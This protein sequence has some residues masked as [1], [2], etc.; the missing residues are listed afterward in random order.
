M[1]CIKKHI[2]PQTSI[3]SDCWKS[4]D[5]LSVEGYIHHTVNHS[6]NFVDPE[7]RAHTNTIERTWREV[8]ANVPRY[9]QRKK[10]MAGYLPE[11]IFKRKFP[12]YVDRVHEFCLAAAELYN[13]YEL[14][15]KCVYNVV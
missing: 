11:Y 7:T 5:S 15:N 9:G 3:I 10:H 4:Y 14:G 2:R 1:R 13:T 12:N 6:K 8:R